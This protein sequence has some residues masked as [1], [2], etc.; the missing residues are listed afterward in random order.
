VSIA[1]AVAADLPLSPLLPELLAPLLECAELSVLPLDFADASAFAEAP[2]LPEAPA[3]LSDFELPDVLAL[4]SECD[5][6]SDFELPD[7][8]A[9]L[10]ECDELSCVAPAFAL[11][12]PLPPA[13][14]EELDEL[15]DL[16]PP[17]AVSELPPEPAA[18]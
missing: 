10:S 17:V 14:L 4:L 12:S 2:A 8:L 5:E 15:A 11:A 18:F 3:L 13:L 16:P 9:L 7:V 6:L 1:P